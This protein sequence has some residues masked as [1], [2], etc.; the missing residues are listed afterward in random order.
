MLLDPD[1]VSF[2][3]TNGEFP[4]RDSA[5]GYDAHGVDD[6]LTIDRDA[7]ATPDLI[8]REHN[9]VLLLHA[10][11]DSHDHAITIVVP[12]WQA[13]GRSLPP[14][15]S[16]RAH[17]LS[18]TGGGGRK[19][20]GEVSAVEPLADGDVA[21]V[22]RQVGED[23]AEHLVWVVTGPQRLIDSVHAQ[24]RLIRLRTFDDDVVA[25]IEPAASS[26]Y[27]EVREVRAQPPPSPTQPVE[28]HI[29]AR[30]R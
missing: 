30:A 9:G 15:C 23:R 12:R 24:Q 25:D 27:E 1:D 18:E 17:H 3:P 28:T 16:T 19:V 6:A 4:R 26:G 11:D 22:R 20:C 2:I 8:E 13:K 21:E 29:R 7:E 14:E 10:N 5:E